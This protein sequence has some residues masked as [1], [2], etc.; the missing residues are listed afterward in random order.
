DGVKVSLRSKTKVD[1]RKIAEVFGG[2][3]HIRASGMKLE[4][5]TIEEAKELIVS[6]LKKSL[7]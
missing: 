1:V 2:G 3:G 5:K 4:N 7:K 6:E